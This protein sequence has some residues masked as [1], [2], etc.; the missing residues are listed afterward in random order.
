MENAGLSEASYVLAVVVV[1]VSVDEEREMPLCALLF[2]T[3]DATR[4]D[5]RRNALPP[6]SSCSHDRARWAQ[7]RAQERDY[8]I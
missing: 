2:M 6:P 4:S 1:V 3:R 7:H 8:G 5:L